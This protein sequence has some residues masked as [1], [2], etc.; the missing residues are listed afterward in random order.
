MKKSYVTRMSTADPK[1]IRVLESA[2]TA[3][4][5]STLLELAVRAYIATPDGKE[6]VGRLPAAEGEGKKGGGVAK[7][8]QVKSEKKQPEI[9]I[10][11][12]IPLDT[13]LSSKK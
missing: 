1:I 5:L 3:R 7:E 12:K 2:K 4:S 6:F 8:R 10:V 13:F 9:K 11:S